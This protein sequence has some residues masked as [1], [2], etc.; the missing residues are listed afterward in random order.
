MTLLTAEK[1]DGLALAALLADDRSLEKA[2]D[3]L[4]AACAEALRRRL[5][6]HA[7]LPRAQ[8]VTNLLERVRPALS[9]LPSSLPARMVA[10]L[11]PRLP[12]QVLRNY[13]GDQLE[14]RG[15]FRVAP[16][17]VPVLLRLARA[18]ARAHSE[19]A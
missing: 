15:G 11:A 5:S 7:D 9:S 16:E 10:A 2:A 6:A 13:P 8:V 1:V 19:G 17:L 4:G 18:E 14:T 12:Q 3:G